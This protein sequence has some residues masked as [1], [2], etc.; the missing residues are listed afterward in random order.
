MLPCDDHSGIRQRGT[1]SAAGSLLL[2]C[3]QHRQGKRHRSM[4][5]HRFV[6]WNDL[7]FIVRNRGTMVL[8]CNGRV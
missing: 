4:E 3:S 5:Y 2:S 8:A 1:L 7:G 6:A